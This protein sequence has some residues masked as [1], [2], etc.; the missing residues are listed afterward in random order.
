[1]MK[2][3]VDS[4]HHPIKGVYRAP[5]GSIVIDDK[6]AFSRYQSEKSRLLQMKE[7]KEATNELAKRLDRL[8]NAI[9]HLLS[10]I[11]QMNLERK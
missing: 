5:D 1:M 3:V 2:Q 11:S 7:T 4:N 6:E 9:E 8:E 10:N